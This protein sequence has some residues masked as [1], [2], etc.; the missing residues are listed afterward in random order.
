[1][2]RTSTSFPFLSRSVGAGILLGALAL[3]L[4]PSTA[5]AGGGN[6]FIRGDANGDQFVDV[7]DAVSIFFYVTGQQSLPCLDAADSNDSGSV[8]VVDIVHVLGY[9]PNLCGL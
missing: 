4:L 9:F 1:M 6:D 7:A 5:S 3:L 2:N 8:N